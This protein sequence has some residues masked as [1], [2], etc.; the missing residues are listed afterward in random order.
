[1]PKP[2]PLSVDSGKVRRL[3]RF[4]SIAVA[5][6]SLLSGWASSSAALGQVS[7]AQVRQD[8]VPQAQIRQPQTAQQQTAKPQAARGQNGQSNIRKGQTRS[9]QWTGVRSLNPPPSSVSTQR[10]PTT[11][12]PASDGQRLPSIPQGAAWSNAPTSDPAYLPAPHRVESRPSTSSSNT[13]RL[14]YQSGYLPLPE[15]NATPSPGYGEPSTPN[16]A[17]RFNFQGAPWSYVLKNFADA[18][19]MS[20]FASELPSGNFSFFSERDYTLDEALD[21]LNDFLLRQS[22]LLVRN[23]RNLT[24]IS[25]SEGKIQEGKTAFVP[26]PRIETLGRNELVSVAFSLRTPLTP[27]ALAE[28]QQLLTPLGSLLPLSNTNRLIVTDVG[29]SLRRLK[30]LIYGSGPAASEIQQFVFRLRHTTAAEM[31]TALNNHLGGGSG[32]VVPASGT[33][34]V[35]GS[36]GVITASATSGNFTP[37]IVA[38]PQTN[39]L[40][41]EGTPQEI[42][43]VDAMIREL[44]RDPGQVEIKALLVEVDLGNAKD[45]GVEFGLQDSVLFDR[46]VVDNVVTIAETFTSP[47]GV[48]TTNQRILSQTAAPGFN[49]NGAPLGNNVAINPSRVGQQGVSSLGLGRVSGDLGVS[50]LVLS[51]SSNSV[52]VLIRALEQKFELE[53]LSCPSIRAVNRRNATIQTGQLVPIVDGVNISPNGTANPVVRQDRAGIVLQ[54]KPIIGANGR[55]EIEVQA[56]KSAYQLVSGSGTPIFVD[57]ST[58]SVITAPVKDIKTV[59]TTIAAYS[60]QTIVLGGMITTEESELH[61]KV[62]ILGDIPLIKKLFTVDITRA[63]RKELLI[64][65]TP[66]IIQSEWQSNALTQQAGSHMSLNFDECHDLHQEYARAMNQETGAQFQPVDPE[67][68]PAIPLPADPSSP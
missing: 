22:F 37:T 43:R 46:S 33:G 48:Q 35:P 30:N 66:T 26:L 16:S 67:S 15:Q 62:P 40:L 2:R 36:G 25:T 4:A 8:Q 14:A 42:A 5:V 60:G 54:V 57:A 29:W 65:L 55:V 58:G 50:G 49:F 19:G 38:E 31:A 32:G 34:G 68:V 52:N 17:W 39:S 12:I 59:D 47:N 27:E 11:G 45:R 3:L 28:Y 64:I 9:G 51:A 61:R 20:L 13:T 24:L 44:D 41:I 23:E 10:S 6:L 21:I 56:E 7:K 1:M 63:N 53:V 18:S